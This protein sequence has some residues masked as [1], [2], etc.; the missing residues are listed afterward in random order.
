MS[1][2][3]DTLTLI[4]RTRLEAIFSG[5]WDKRLP[6]D[7]DGRMFLD[8]NYTCIRAVVE[9]LNDCKITNSDCA[10]KMPHL[11]EED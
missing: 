1:V 8:V 11:G 10:P 9:Y 2:T 6:R 5:R 3:R 4:K 7:K